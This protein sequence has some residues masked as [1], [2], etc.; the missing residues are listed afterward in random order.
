MNNSKTTG[1]ITFWK[2][3]SC[4]GN[5]NGRIDVADVDY[6]CCS[7]EN[8]IKTIDTLKLR[9]YLFLVNV[10]VNN[11]FW[12]GLRFFFFSV[13]CHWKHDKFSILFC[14]I[15]CVDFCK[16]LV[17]PIGKMMES[18]QIPIVLSGLKRVSNILRWKIQYSL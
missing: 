5:N 14:A 17:L 8:F 15:S 10:T 11:A 12:I 1:R 3:F 4:Q 18:K 9:K 7:L 6:G 13:V 16:H 2:L